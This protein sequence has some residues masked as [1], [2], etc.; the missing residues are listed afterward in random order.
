MWSVRLQRSITHL[1]HEAEVALKP[2]PGSYDVAIVN[3]GISSFR[4]QIPGLVESGA[5]VVGHAGHKEKDLH[6]EGQRLGCTLTATNSE[7]TFKLEG[8]L[9]RLVG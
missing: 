1:G 8:L 2:G 5:K 6:T 9:A 4:D 7:L 3:L